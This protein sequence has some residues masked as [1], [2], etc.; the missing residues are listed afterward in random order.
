MPSSLNT[1]TVLPK[2]AKPTPP[3][4]VPPKM[5]PEIRKIDALVAKITGAGCSLP[6]IKIVGE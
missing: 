1:K 5:E 6:I 4:V 3:P 2:K